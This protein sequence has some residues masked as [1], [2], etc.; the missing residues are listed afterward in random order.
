MEGRGV[1]GAGAMHER[2]AAIYSSSRVVIL[3]S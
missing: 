3:F 2:R 1:A